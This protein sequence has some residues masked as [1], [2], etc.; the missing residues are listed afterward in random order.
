MV[1]RNDILYCLI[2]LARADQGQK[3]IWIKKQINF[4]KYIQQWHTA[5]SLTADI[6]AALKIDS[7]K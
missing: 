6:S 4:D 5:H 7:W 3:G 1:T 2:Q